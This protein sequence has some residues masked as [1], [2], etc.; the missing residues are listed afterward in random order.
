M[1]G[2]KILLSL[3]CARLVWHDAFS[4]NWEGEFILLVPPVSIIGRVLQHLELCEGKG[5]LIVP[6]WPSSYFWPILINDFANYVQDI[7][8]VKGLN[9]LIHG[10]N[11]NSL[12]GSNQ[13]HGFML[14]IKLDCSKSA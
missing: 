9:I 1:Q 5:V 6:C 12:L 3:S 7:L 2:K 10:Y 13:F 11:Q 8:K 14:V 4:F